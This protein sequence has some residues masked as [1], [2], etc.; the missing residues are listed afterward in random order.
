MFWRVEF[1]KL[2]DVFISPNTLVDMLAPYVI[3][4]IVALVMFMLDWFNTFTIYVTF[5]VFVNEYVNELFNMSTVV[6]SR[7]ENIPAYNPHIFATKLSEQFE[8]LVWE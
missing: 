3:I 7:N 2:D 5:E 1:E 8:I 4:N 6:F